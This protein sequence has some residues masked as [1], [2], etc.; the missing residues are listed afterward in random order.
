[1]LATCLMPAQ[2]PRPTVVVISIDGF[3]AFDLDNERLPIPTLRRL[4]KEGSWA[5][6]MT[7]INP[8][9]TWPN[10]TTLVTGVDARKHGVLF[11]GML[12]RDVN[13]PKV[14]PW[15][16]K[17]KMVHAP[18]VY[19]A[20]YE[21]GLTT[22]QVD[23]VA[24]YGAKTITWQFPEKPDPD[25]P[26]EREMESEGLV[27]RED[28]ADFLTKS[29]AAWRDQI[30]T[31][32]AAHI[33]RQHQPNLLLF[34]L[35]NLD[36][37]QHT[38][39]PNTPAAYSA[40]ALADSRVHDILGTIEAAGLKD[41]TTV[42]IVSDHG[43]RAVKRNIRPNAIAKD[44]GVITQGGMAMIYSKT[45]NLRERFLGIEGIAQAL[46]PQDY[47]RI[48]LPT[49]AQSSQSPDL[50]LIAKPGY[51]LT[52]GSD[53]PAVVDAGPGEGQHGYLNS[54]PDMDAIFIAWGRGIR[55]G[56]RADRISNLDVAPT[57]AALLGVKLPSA[58]GRALADF[59]APQSH[60]IASRMYYNRPECSE[61]ATIPVRQTPWSA[62][63]S[64]RYLACPNSPTRGSG[65]DEGV[66]PTNLRPFLGCGYAAL[67]GR[68]PGLQTPAWSAL[69]PISRPGT[70]GPGGP[71][72]TR[73]SAPLPAN[74]LSTL[75]P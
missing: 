2:P 5:K 20:A 52:R 39:G 49:P 16:D 22:A 7:T 57:I 14:E 23:W 10:H 37:I 31:A 3:P 43:F 44:A 54:D 42:L 25:G 67:W 15:V 40:I 24:I 12:N 65:A 13:P 61:A 74:P 34:H 51:A 55:A 27:T 66:C 8:T 69:A 28:V 75:A 46:T 35:L 68:S 45:P 62:A 59:L 73:G 11:N 64:A 56:A 1:M 41:R 30:W 17:D 58:D 29:N 50:L 19:D 36:G 60:N 38:Y 53:L 9:V 71:A 48:G 4:I 18:T 63:G 21:A 32:A 72:Q 33:L 6:R 70:A 47:D 26:I